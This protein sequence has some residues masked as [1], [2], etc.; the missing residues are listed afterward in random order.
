MRQ[1]SNSSFKVSKRL[2]KLYSFY[3]SAVLAT[4]FCMNSF[5]IGGEVAMMMS[6]PQKQ[7]MEKKISAS[8]NDQLSSML[9]ELL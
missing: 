2:P 1:L 3:S 5:S 9:L 7:Q 6:K 4:Y 8:S